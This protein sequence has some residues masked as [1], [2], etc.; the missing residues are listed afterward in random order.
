MLSVWQSS[1]VNLIHCYAIMVYLEETP[2]APAVAVQISTIVQNIMAGGY[3][4]YHQF[5]NA[6]SFVYGVKI[7]NNEF[8]NK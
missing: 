8:K 3:L 7:M 5:G 2:F 1:G 4:G 6:V